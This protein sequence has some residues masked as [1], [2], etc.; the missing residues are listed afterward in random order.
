M[1]AARGEPDI[2][3][4]TAVVTVAVSVERCFVFVW[5]AHT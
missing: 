5:A 3:A 2:A 4:T 1:L